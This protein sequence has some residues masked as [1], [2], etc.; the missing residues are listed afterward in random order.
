M[1]IDDITSMTKED[2]ENLLR[3]MDDEAISKVADMFMEAVE[4]G[5]GE[6]TPQCMAYIAE[7]SRFLHEGCC[8]AADA[9][10][11][12]ML[13]FLTMEIV[14]TLQCKKT[15]VDEGNKE[16]DEELN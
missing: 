3:E 14:Q 7:K 16:T 6:C 13:D 15:P 8:K 5:G 10:K 9:T 2:V 1:T 12:A 11:N 4:I